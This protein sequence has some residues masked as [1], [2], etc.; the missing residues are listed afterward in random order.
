MVK[1]LFLSSKVF[2]EKN[3]AAV[4]DYIVSKM[5][6][7]KNVKF[8]GHFHLKIMING[9]WPAKIKFSDWNWKTFLERTQLSL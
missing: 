5:H 1:V 2:V 8:Y 3:S 6:F 7:S 4:I 9:I